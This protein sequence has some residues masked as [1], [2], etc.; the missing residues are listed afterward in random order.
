MAVTCRTWHDKVTISSEVT[1]GKQEVTPA[2]SGPSSLALSHRLAP[3]SRAWCRL[4]RITTAAHSR[5]CRSERSSNT[6][7]RWPVV[8]RLQLLRV[9]EDR[10]QRGALTRRRAPS[11]D[12]DVALPTPKREQAAVQLPTNLLKSA[13]Q[14]DSD[15]AAQ[16]ALINVSVVQPGHLGATI[17]TQWR[18]S[19][20][21]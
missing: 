6:S 8:S 9:E 14:A 18:V 21:R 12:L 1:T 11:N 5:T 17:T 10:R 4:A 13:K 3:T 7:G 20:A 2:L 15:D 16:L 19:H